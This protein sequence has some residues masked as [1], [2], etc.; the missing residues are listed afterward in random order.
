MTF[1]GFSV[2]LRIMSK[3]RDKELIRLRDEALCRRYY[4]WTE[5]QRLRFDDALRVLSE[6]EFFI[7]E[8]RIMAII[9]RMSREGTD[10]D[11]KPLPKVKVPR[12]K[13][14]QLELFPVL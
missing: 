14:S 12:L 9:R 10:K 3:G 6:R 7:S 5:V 11:I 4:Y 2:F 8:E 13:A 1:S